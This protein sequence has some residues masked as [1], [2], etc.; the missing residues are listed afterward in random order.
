MD[1]GNRS[2]TI[3]ALGEVTAYSDAKGQTFSTTYD[4]LSRPLIRTESDLTT[5]WTWGTSAVNHNVGK[6]QSV[7]EP[8]YAETYLFDSAGRPIDRSISSDAGYSYD[9]TYSATTGLLDT[10]SYPTSTAGYRLKL[11]YGYQ[12]GLPQQVKDANASTIFWQATTANPRGQVTQETLGNGIV[13]NRA[14]DAVT[15]W[16][17]S[18]QSGVGGGAAVQ[19]ESYLFDLVGN[20]TQRQNGNAGLTE[21]F[22]YDNLYRLDHSVL[23]SVTTLQLTYDA[24][25]DITSR[26]DIAGGATWTYDAT[27][28]H[29]LTQA[30]NSSLTYTYDQNGNAITRNGY[31]L[32]WSSYNYPTSINSNGKNVAFSYDPNRLR[33]EQIYTSGA[34]TET[35]LYVGGLME[36]VT[37]G[38]TVDWR[39]YIREG[40]QLIA[41][42]SRQ[43]S[44]TNTTHYVLEDHE[45]SLAKI[46]DGTGATTVSESFSAFGTR[47]DP[48]TWSSACDCADLSA[49]PSAGK[50]LRDRTPSAVRAWD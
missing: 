6:L 7:S 21:N 30:G 25:G 34:G 20:V 1:L 49:S 24:M 27:R 37:T 48:T 19:N 22:Y 41:I 18:N 15:G 36:K 26:N 13:T 31:Q 33:Y 23:G 50:A 32:V 47:R 28:K 14:F 2:Y 8:G 29:A 10:L 42:M 44:G 12:N 35:T 11:Q 46:T 4:A 17:G 39:H 5:T 45:G 3:D 43:N 16:L 40:N 9:T 38:S